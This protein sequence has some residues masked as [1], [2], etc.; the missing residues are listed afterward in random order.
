MPSVYWDKIGHGKNCKQ[1]VK[2]AK[3]EAL[4]GCS[5]ARLITKDG[6]KKGEKIETTC[7][8]YNLNVGG[9]DIIEKGSSVISVQEACASLD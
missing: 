3:M 8:L 9:I 5:R 4:L 2:D 1:A 7:E 6:R